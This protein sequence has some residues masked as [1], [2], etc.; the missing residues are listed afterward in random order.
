MHSPVDILGVFPSLALVNK[1]A[2]ISGGQMSFRDGDFIS[3]AYI[4]HW[5][6]YILFSLKLQVWKDV[7]NFK[8]WLDTLFSIMQL[9]QNTQYRQVKVRFVLVH[10]FRGLSPWVVGSEAEASG[11]SKVSPLK[12]AGKQRA[13]KNTREGGARDQTFP[14][15][16][17]LMTW[18]ETTRRELHWSPELSHALQ[19]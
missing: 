1:V 18:S 19:H 6:K 14:P 13:R 17:C 4:L 3:P 8:R 9:R 15:R 7:E 5:F 16:W 10:S 12:A 2:M 11:Q